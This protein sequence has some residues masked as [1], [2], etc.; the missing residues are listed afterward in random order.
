MARDVKPFATTTTASD[1][2]GTLRNTVA[3][4]ELQCRPQLIQKLTGIGRP[5]INSLLDRVNVLPPA[6]KGGR[7][8]RSVKSLIESLPR[9]VD[10]SLFL[11]LY[12][13][14]LTF[15]GVDR[16]IV[17][18]DAFIRAL[19][20]F[21]S[22]NPSS[23]F[24][25]DHAVLV[26]TLYNEGEVILKSC[27]ACPARFLESRMPVL[28]RSQVTSGECPNCRTLATEERGRPVVKLGDPAKQRQLLQSF[29][30]G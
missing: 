28:I 30:L 27:K 4:L 12:V 20:S 6:D 26:I 17:H 22:H 15:Y 21:K 14:F 11:K 23:D 10:A 2:F 1:P 5:T 3:L 18:T 8:P 13:E 7:H 24:T 19:T 16:G 9:H 25:A 29:A